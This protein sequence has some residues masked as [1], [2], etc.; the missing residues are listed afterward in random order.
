[1]SER[2]ILDRIDA[3][4]ARKFEIDDD[5]KQSNNLTDY[6]RWIADAIEELLRLNV[7]T[8]ED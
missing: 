6:T 8:K 3:L 4:L 1:M 2:E 7:S 5:N